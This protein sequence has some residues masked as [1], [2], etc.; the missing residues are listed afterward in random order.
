L[1]SQ[2]INK[3]TSLG[4]LVV[5]LLTVLLAWFFIDTGS[6]YQSLIKP[7]FQAPGWLLVSI[8]IVLLICIGIA[9]YLVIMGNSP[10]KQRI[11]V[12]YGINLALSVLWF[13]LFFT[14]QHPLLAFFIIMIIWASTAAMIATSSPVSEKTV[15]LLLP[16][17]LWITY[18]GVLN[19][20]IIMLNSLW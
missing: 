3:R 1:S 12:L 2:N 20:S 5:L 11:L 14:L 8:W 16:Y 6:W 19:H 15:R 18:V 10:L 9:S 13:F 4:I 7:A 17:L